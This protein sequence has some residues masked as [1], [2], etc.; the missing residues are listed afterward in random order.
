[1]TNLGWILYTEPQILDYQA[2]LEYTKQAAERE[3]A[4]QGTVIALN[5]LGVMYEEGLV[6][7]PDPSCSTS[8]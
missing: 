1:M 6:A 8:S 4:S 2:A 5:N 7:Q 3:V